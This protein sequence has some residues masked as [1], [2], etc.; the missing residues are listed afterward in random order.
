MGAEVGEPDRDRLA[1][2]QAQDSPAPGQV[3][4]PRDQ[5]FVHAGVHE[6]LQLPVAAEHAERRVPGAEKIPGSDDD[7]PQ[8]HRQAQIHGHQ[9]IGAQQPAQPTLRGLH[10]T[11]PVDQLHQQLIQLQP[12]HVREAQPVSRYADSRAHQLSRGHLEVWRVRARS[13]PVRP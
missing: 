1:G 3:A 2:Q 5:L 13:G 11:G 9:R 12:R 6:L 4:D 7:L 8:H 10:V